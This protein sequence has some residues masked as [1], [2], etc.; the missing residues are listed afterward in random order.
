MVTFPSSGFYA[1]LLTVLKVKKYLVI[2][3]HLKALGGYRES[4]NWE[5]G[6]VMRVFIAR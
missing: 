6:A 5:P 1:S 3:S 4:S 2:L